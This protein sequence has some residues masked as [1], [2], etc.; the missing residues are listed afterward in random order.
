[1]K[2][3]LNR[4]LKTTFL[5]EILLH[6]ELTF[7]II[8]IIAIIFI[9]Y[10]LGRHKYTHLF[11]GPLFLLNFPLKHIV[12]YLITLGIN[13]LILQII[14]IFQDKNKDNK[15]WWADILVYL[16]T[17][18]NLALFMILKFIN[19]LNIDLKSKLNIS[20]QYMVLVPK[21][22]YLG[23]KKRGVI[24]SLV[25]IFFLP[26]LLAGPIIPTDKILQNHI[27]IKR[28][29]DKKKS[30]EDKKSNSN[31]PNAKNTPINSTNIH[32]LTIADR[33][34]NNDY[35]IHFF[36]FAAWSA[37]SFTKS[38]LLTRFHSTKY[39]LFYLYFYGL[40]FRAQY[41]SIWSLASL[42]FL[43]SG[44]EF[45]NVNF[46]EFELG[47][48][49]RDHAKNWNIATVVWLREMVFYPIKSKYGYYFASTA[50]LMT[51]SIWHGG[52]P[53]YFLMFIGIGM[54]S[55]F[56]MAIRRKITGISG[57][58]S[59]HLRENC[60]NTV[61]NHIFN[62]VID[63][64]KIIYNILFFTFWSV[65]FYFTDVKESFVVWRRVWFYGVVYYVIGF[66][67]MLL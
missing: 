58:F 67:C 30:D 16:L 49:T 21:V 43:F 1:M 65:P 48:E 46:K 54:F 15:N 55:S 37:L 2:L 17:F 47:T 39:P 33:F 66:F 35:F 63:V 13:L 7:L 53:S 12:S 31:L 6:N 11:F 4:Y 3:F 8:N 27:N 34:M 40:A 57:L 60:K 9:S 10:K 26:A 19:P 45:R 62:N 22:Y 18:T 24:D 61:L 51:T 23:A 64:I 36:S 14:Y 52:Y 41:Y 29:D 38:F 59:D 44:V 50:T 28:V 42:N 5:K 56:D 20:V 25:Y 32:N